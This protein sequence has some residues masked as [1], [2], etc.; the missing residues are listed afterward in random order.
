[1]NYLVPVAAVVGLIVGDQLE[2]VVDRTG[3]RRNLAPPWSACPTCGA[4]DTGMALV[5]IARVVY[6]RRG[7]SNC[8]EVVGHP[9]RPAIMAVVCAAVMAGF[10]DKIGLH[11]ALAPYAVLAAGLVAISAVDLERLIIP[12][13]ILY[14]S[15]ATVAVLLVLAAMLDAQWGSLG[16]AALASAVA[17]A[18]FFVIHVA[19]PRGM[20][21]GDVRLSA[22][23]GLSAGWFGLG[24]AFVAFLAAFLLGSL[25]GL[26]VMAATGQGRKTR[27]PFGPFLAIGAVLSIVAGDPIVNLLF[28]HTT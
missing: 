17:L 26:V 10:A 14:P 21:F 28:H 5:P 6:R 25:V 1:M 18:I 20:G 8:G 9:W 13:R 11:I 23:I 19:A 15:S 12:N 2:V 4:P 24:H 27:V 3:N 7:C 22:L 16:R